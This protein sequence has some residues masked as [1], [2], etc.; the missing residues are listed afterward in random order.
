MRG[1][2]PIALDFLEDKDGETR[3]FREYL[4]RLDS[5]T[6]VRM[7]DLESLQA[8]FAQAAGHFFSPEI[9]G[10]GYRKFNCVGCFCTSADIHAGVFERNPELLDDMLLHDIMIYGIVDNEE[11]KVTLR[12][13][14]FEETRH[15]QIRSTASRPV[16]IEYFEHIHGES[17]QTLTIDCYNARTASNAAVGFRLNKNI[18]KGCKLTLQ[19][20]R[21][22]RIIIK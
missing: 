8:I 5:Q 17:L 3:V 14:R 18:R 15:L 13:Y 4:S 6:K 16:G 2:L 1:A 7:S 21:A 20:N 10:H 22:A 11:S 9:S 19:G 12:N